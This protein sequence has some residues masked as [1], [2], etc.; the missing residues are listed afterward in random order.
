MTAPRDSPSGSARAPSQSP[1]DLG[2]S[3]ELVAAGF[4]VA[5]VL[6]AE[7]YDGLV[8]SA[9]RSATLLP[10]ARSVVVLG[11]GGRAFGE[12]FLGSPEA[13]ETKHPV[14][15]FTRRVVSA[16]VAGL[17]EAAAQ[18]I[19]YWEKRG[20]AYADFVALGRAAGLGAC[21]RLGLLLHPTYGPWFSLRAAIITSA[22]LPS[23]EEDVGFAPCVDCP[24]PCAEACPGEAVALAGF[25]AL[26]C[27]ETTRGNAGCASRCAARHAC[28]I[29]G[30][31]AFSPEVESRFR[32]A[33]IAYSAR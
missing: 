10:G 18:P 23:G 3:P 7:R 32:A 13:R 24:A 22:L 19:F 15:R 9:W 16:G 5:G 1:S 27:A 12:S 29:G 4:N 26:A 8:S 33:V 20:E 31:H 25:D 17:A 28:V 6:R 14:D 30:E 11:C 21:G 2:L